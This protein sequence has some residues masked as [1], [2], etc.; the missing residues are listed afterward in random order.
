MIWDG[1]SPVTM[2]AWKDTPGETLLYETPVGTSIAVGGIVTVSGYAPKDGNDVVWEVFDAANGSKLGESV[3]HMSCSDDDMDGQTDDPAF[4]NDCGKRQGDGKGSSGLNDWL[5]E[6]MVD[7]EGV[8]SCSETFA[9]GSL[10]DTLEP[11]RI[12]LPEIRR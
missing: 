12:F 10:G 2:K 4:P 11:Y 8:L 5:L 3:F 7:N 1:A 6:G 9:A